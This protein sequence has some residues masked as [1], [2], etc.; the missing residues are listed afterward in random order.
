MREGEERR[1]KI[2]DKGALSLRSFFPPPPHNFSHQPPA[3]SAGHVLERIPSYTLQQLEI[4]VSHETR[5]Q[6]S[7]A[8]PPSQ[9]SRVM[10][11]TVSLGQ[12][13]QQ[14]AAPVSRQYRGSFLGK[15]TC[16]VWEQGLNTK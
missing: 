5:P 12:Q 14:A 3:H 1:E 7:S 10:E 9:P 6:Q 13:P 4:A 2:G 8:N 16:V 15:Q 11:R